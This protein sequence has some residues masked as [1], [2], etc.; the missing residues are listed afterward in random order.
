M[1]YAIE[2]LEKDRRNLERTIKNSELM[3]HD[4]QKASIDLQKLSDLKIAIKLL[5]VRSR[6]SH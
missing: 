4:I 3:K 6:K 2:L 1:E 5:S